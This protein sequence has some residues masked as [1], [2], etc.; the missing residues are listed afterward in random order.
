MLYVFVEKRHLKTTFDFNFLRSLLVVFSLVTLGCG[1]PPQY[2]NEGSETPAQ[3][4]VS[5]DTVTNFP[6]IINGRSYTQILTLQNLSTTVPADSLVATSSLST[7]FSFP[8]GSYPGTNGNCGATLAPGQSCLIEINLD[9][10]ITGSYSSSIEIAFFDGLA[11]QTLVIPL[12]A[13][14]RDPY[15]ASLSLSPSAPHDFGV[16][17]IG[18][19]AEL[20]MTLNNSGEQAAAAMVFSGLSSPYSIV[21][22]TCGVLVAEA[23][24]CSFTIRFTPL[25]QSTFPQTLSVQYNDGSTPQAVNKSV[26][27]EGRVAGFLNVSQG[28]S[29]DYGVINDTFQSDRLLTVQNTG[30]GNATGINFSGL[31]APYSIASNACPATLT[32]GQS[33]NLTVRF[34]PTATNLYTDTLDIGFFDGFSGQT[35]APTFSGEGFAN[36]LLLSLITPASSPSNQ[37]TPTVRVSSTISGLNVRLYNNAGCGTQ[38]GTVAAAGASL[39][40]SPTLSEGTYQ[41]HARAIDSDGN[42]SA[43]SVSLVDYIYDNTAPSRPGAISL[44]S[45]FTSSATTAPNFSWFASPSG[46]VVDYQVGI[47]TSAAGGNADGGWTSK[48]NVLSANETGLSMT[49][50]QYYYVSIQSIDHVGLTSPTARVSTSSFRYDSAPPT[51]PTGLNEGSDGSSTN[52][53][54]VSWNIS[55]DTC[56]IARYEVAI[57]EDSNGNNTLDASE[58]G[59]T[60][61]F[62]D[63]GLVTSHRFNAISLN[64]GV[65]H[66]T[67]VRAVDTT[68]RLSTAAVSDP[69]IVYDPSEELPDM[70]LWLDGNDPA[71]V[72]DENGRDALDALFTGNVSNW[73]DKSGSA[74]DHDFNAVNGSSRPTYN[75]SNFTVD[76][77]GSNSVMTTNNHSEIN[78]ATTTQRNITVAFRT[79]GDIASR[80]VLYEEGGNVRGMNVYVFNNRIYCGFYNDPN[81]VGGSDDPDID[82]P[83]TSVAS[84]VI[85]PN[86]NYFVTWVFN[87]NTNPELQCYVNSASIGTTRSTSR[88]FAHSGAVGLGA[89][90]GQSVFEDGSVPNSGH[91][92]LGNIYEVMLFNNAPTLGDV[93]N[94][95]TYLDNKWN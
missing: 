37:S 38:V 20:E 15:P 67:S 87:Y 16:I 81:G 91:N 27:G 50:C 22:N 33:C 46:D 4:S 48:G 55:T 1:A 59:N 88:L 62:T 85:S 72:R 28:L 6:E 26:T 57:S 29:F 75:G 68:G 76:F 3:V 2:I 18:G 92:F 35:A 19:F 70:I 5:A 34:A 51:A 41:F 14:S 65:T 42:L 30:G 79:S 7:P 56:G 10:V 93:T 32:P 52:S 47:S 23:S 40:F 58:I 73:L 69:W 43:C 82:Q 36:P 90:N 54:T 83:F 25:A 61:S 21:N 60:I 31:A 13:V 86:T 11:D 66:Y 45:N 63:V 94:V 39:D 64:N 80:Q 78:T 49:E 12:T 71:S 95:H 9:P 17:A 24:Q 53:A 74:T 44:A 89:V 77:D 84:P 8:G